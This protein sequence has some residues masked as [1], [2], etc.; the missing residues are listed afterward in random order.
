MGALYRLAFPNGKSYVGITSGTAAARWQKHVRDARAGKPWLVQKAIRK[1]G[2]ESVR[3]ETLAIADDW[4]YLQLVERNAIRVL[5]TFGSG[6]YNMTAGGDGAMGVVQSP[7]SRR[8]KAD[9]QIGVTK[10]HGAAVSAGLRASSK[11]AAYFDLQRHV[12]RER[13]SSPEGRAAVAARNRTREITPALRAALSAGQRKSEKARASIAA[14]NA[15]K[16]GVPAT[17]EAND[18][19]RKSMLLRATGVS[20]HVPSKRWRARVTIAGHESSLGY[21]DT[22]DEARAARQAAVTAYFEGATP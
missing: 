18:K 6:G 1:Y 4:A 5:G 13:N 20:F 22:E 11:A 15:S 14:L 10:N 7:V 2:T 21:F 8:K 9:A 16:R 19:R 3:V 12:L 17:R